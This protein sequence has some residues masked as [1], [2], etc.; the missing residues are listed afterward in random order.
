MHVSCVF[1]TLHDD[2]SYC[3]ILSSITPI[4]CSWEVQTEVM[5]IQYNVYYQPSG[6]QRICCRTSINTYISFLHLRERKREQGHTTKLK[7][8]TGLTGTPQTS[9]WPPLR[10]GPWCQLTSMGIC[11]SLKWSF[12][13]KL[14]LVCRV[15]GKNTT[16]NINH[17]L[18]LHVYHFVHFLPKTSRGG[19]KAHL[20]KRFL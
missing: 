9:G 4:Q 15:R 20:Y 13:R 3:A 17:L 7:L 11:C 2:G 1:P 16:L 18:Y 14:S 19:E 8:A 10:V 5:S 12:P 6:L